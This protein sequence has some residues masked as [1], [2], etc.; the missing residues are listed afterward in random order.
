[1]T[2][3]P[4]GKPDRR[5]KRKLAPK[6]EPGGGERTES[7][8]K[9]D[10][11]MGNLSSPISGEA[12]ED[13]SKR[14]FPDTDL[15]A[16][17]RLFDALR[18]YLLARLHEQEAVII[19]EAKAYDAISAAVFKLNTAVRDLRDLR[20]APERSRPSRKGWD[21]RRLD[22][23]MMGVLDGLNTLATEAR[24]HAGFS[25]WEEAVKF[26]HSIGLDEADCRLLAEIALPSVELPPAPRTVVSFGSKGRE[27]K[28]TSRSSKVRSPLAVL[29]VLARLASGLCKKNAEKIRQAREGATRERL[30]ARDELL[31]KLREFWQTVNAIGA[32]NSENA[33]FLDF[34]DALN[35]TLP[36]RSEC[37]LGGRATIRAAL[38]SL[39]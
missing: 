35:K 31:Q 18:T 33:H 29:L 36:N 12:W 4:G 34:L 14:F 3:L 8:A 25:S 27:H 6:I 32:P 1:M 19:E 39:L 5:R 22:N 11:K 21:L 7:Y 20:F 9:P 13:L 37:R 17:E 24:F 30:S 23:Q 26:G 15:H 38:K 16:R 2:S 28:V 10:P